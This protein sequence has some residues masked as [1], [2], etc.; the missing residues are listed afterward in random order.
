MSLP[1]GSLLA[2]CLLAADISRWPADNALAGGRWIWTL[3][4]WLCFFIT[5]GVVTVV[6]EGRLPLLVES[7]GAFTRLALAWGW[8]LMLLYAVGAVLSARRYLRTGD[9]LPGYVSFTQIVIA[10]TLLMAGYGRSRYGLAFLLDRFVAVGGFLV[11]QVGLLSDYVR[12]LDCERRKSCELERLVAERT[13][14]LENQREDLLGAMEELRE[15]ER[16]LVQ[17]SRMAAMGEILENIA[18]QWRQPLNLLGLIVQEM[19]LKYRSRQGEDDPAAKRAMEVIGRMSRTIDDFRNFFTPGHEPVRFRVNDA[20]SKIIDMIGASFR[21]IQV[22]IQIAE[23]EELVAFGFPNE[24]SQAI[25]NILMNAMDAFV[26]QPIEDP[27]IVVRLFREG[28][29]GVVVIT[30]NAGGIP[31]V[32][33]DRVFEPYFTTKG[34]DRGTG[35]GLYMAK[36]LIVKNMKGKLTVRNTGDGAEFRIE[37][38]S[39]G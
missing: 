21:E 15:K 25:L 1:A 32:I 37:V 31:E 29:N 26:D 8:S 2:V 22:P 16:M 23:E 7:N 17:Q 5:G 35:I 19:G 20:L 9:V 36:T 3:W 6:A 24:F 30:D 38:P 11:M 14:H 28:E 27:R 39:V 10:F 4:G 18:H 33:I 13:S 12:L 34:P